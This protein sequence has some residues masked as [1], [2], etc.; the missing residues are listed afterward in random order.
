MIIMVWPTHNNQIYSP[1]IDYV[2]KGSFGKF[3]YSKYN[4]MDSEKVCNHSLYKRALSLIT[5]LFHLFKNV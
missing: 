5:V 4:I 1:S 3:I 2:E